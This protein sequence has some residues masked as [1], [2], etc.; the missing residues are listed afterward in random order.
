MTTLA[1]KF[2]HSIKK[3]NKDLICKSANELKEKLGDDN[4]I[5]TVVRLF[6]YKSYI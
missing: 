3:K 5:D 2:F 6:D 1:R 4:V